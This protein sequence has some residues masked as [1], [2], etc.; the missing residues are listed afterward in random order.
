MTSEATGTIA[1]RYAAALFELAEQGSALDLV[2]ADLRAFKA[3]V[4]DS[5]DLRRLLKSP[6]LGRVAQEKAIIAVAGGAQF[7]ALTQNFL[8]LV[9]R[10]RRLYAVEGMIT[11]FLARLAAKRGEV[12]A[13]VASAVPLAEPQIAAIGTALKA[14]IGSTVTVETTVDPALL[15][16]LVVQVGSRMVDGSLRTKLQHLQF[17]MKGVG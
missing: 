8:G 4:A 5:A 3:M 2:A 10:N 7:G 11:A 14:A 1:E 16:G 15:G 6:V 13:R 12:T 17:A 9:A